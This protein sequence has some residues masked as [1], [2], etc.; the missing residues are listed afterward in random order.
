MQWDIYH[1]DSYESSQIDHSKASKFTASESRRSEVVTLLAAKVD[2][3][4][5]TCQALWELLRDRTRLTKEELTEKVN[6]IDLRDGKVDRKMGSRG[7]PCSQC[8]RVLSKRRM[9]C[10]YCGEVVDKEH[11]FQ[12]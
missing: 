12:S 5:L 2:S 9:R 7:Q 1:Q 3:L 8:G 10:L 4:A 11:M 6:E